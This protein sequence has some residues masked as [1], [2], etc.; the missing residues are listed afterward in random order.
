MQRYMTV[1]RIFLILSVVNFT[2]AGLAQSRAMLG[3]HADWMKMAG[4]MK[5]TSETWHKPLD[6]LSGPLT[7]RP[8]AMHAHSR[9]GDSSDDSVTGPKADTP[10]DSVIEDG[11][12]FFNQ[13]LKEETD[14]DMVLTVVIGAVAG[15]VS[16]FRSGI[17]TPADPGS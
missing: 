16:Q 12:K 2:L 5:K 6:G 3:A 11:K 10:A 7:K 15:A 14:E 17:T 13:E 1:A 4:D 8:T 9:D